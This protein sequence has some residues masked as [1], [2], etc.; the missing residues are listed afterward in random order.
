MDAVALQKL[1]EDDIAAGNIPFCVVGTVG[2]TD[3][4]SIDPLDKIAELCKKHNMWFHADAAYGSGVV[5]STKYKERVANL[6]LCNSITLDFHK[7]FL[8]P[9]SCSAV[10][11][12]DGKNFEALTIHADYLNRT[13]D[14]EDG[15]TNLVDK[16]IQT[17]RRFDALK[18]WVSFQT[19]GVEGWSK[20][21]STS[22][23]N[24]QYLYEKLAAD[25]DFDV[26]TN[27]EISSVVFRLSSSF[28]GNAER[29]EVNKK[30]RRSLIHDEGVVIGQTVSNGGVCLKFTLLNPLITHE[31]LDSLLVTIKNL[32]N[33]AK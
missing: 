30:V 32:G 23:E 11:L 6:S 1:I 2:T 4:G 28:C 14:E 17:T 21:I 29:D 12:A 7:M 24:A 31:K 8:M 10:L 15:Y 13:E 25:S 18:V 3:F 5:M 19:R 22:M 16:S 27:P 33:K 26:V 9:I 20:L